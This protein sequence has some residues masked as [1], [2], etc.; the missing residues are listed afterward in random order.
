MIR[1]KRTKYKNVFFFDNSLALPISCGRTKA[2]LNREPKSKTSC[3]TYLFNLL[4][5]YSIYRV[6][7]ILQKDE[8]FIENVRQDKFE[9][10]DG[11]SFCKPLFCHLS[12]DMI[13]LIGTKKLGGM[14]E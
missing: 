2:S 7:T 13:D 3:K 1:D 14:K 11:L 4:L 5:F 10:E 6:N 9:K 12:L 8:L